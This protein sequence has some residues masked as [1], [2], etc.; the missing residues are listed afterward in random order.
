MP[1]DDLADS[2]SSATW[3]SRLQQHFKFLTA[4]PERLT[5]SPGRPQTEKCVYV[6]AWTLNFCGLFVFFVS[7][8]ALESRINNS[9]VSLLWWTLFFHCGVCA[10]LLPGRA[11]SGLAD[12]Q[13]L[14]CIS[15]MLLMLSCDRAVQLKAAKVCHSG[16]KARMCRPLSINMH[17]HA[18]TV[19]AVPGA[20]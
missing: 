18:C 20:N 10:F 14:L 5:S 1:A 11:H 3:K 4:V 12:L 2:V 16:C 15:A 8:C 9:S 19:T 6:M 17:H 13:P 7:L